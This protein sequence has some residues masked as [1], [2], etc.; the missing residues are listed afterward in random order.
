MSA[1][2]FPC[3][4]ALDRLGAGVPGDHPAL[5]VQTEDRILPDR[6]EEQAAALVDDGFVRRLDSRLGAVG[7]GSVRLFGFHVRKQ[8]AT[9]QW[10]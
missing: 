2:D 9:W 3:G 1:D 7:A 10:V 6:L 8:P 4:V 5:G